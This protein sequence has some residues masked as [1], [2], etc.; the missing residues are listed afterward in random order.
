MLDSPAEIK[1]KL[2]KQ[3]RGLNN[4]S[5]TSKQR[6]NRRKAFEDLVE[7]V[8]QHLVP[9]THE[10]YRRQNIEEVLEI[11]RIIERSDAPLPVQQLDAI[12][13]IAT[14]RLHACGHLA[15]T[16]KRLKS[17]EFQ[18]CD[19]NSLLGCLQEVDLAIRT[20]GESISRGDAYGDPLRPIARTG[21]DS[22]GEIPGGL[23]DL[24][25]KGRLDRTDVLV[26]LFGKYFSYLESRSER[27]PFQ[28]IKKILFH[29]LQEEEKSAEVNTLFVE[30][31][32]EKKGL[33]RSKKGKTDIVRLSIFEN[34]TGRIAAYVDCDDAMEKAVHDGLMAAMHYMQGTIDAEV[35]FEMFDYAWSVSDTSRVYQQD[36]IGL[37][38]AIAAVAAYTGSE[39]D[40][41]IAVTG[42]LDTSGR[43]GRVDIREKCEIDDPSVLKI[44]VPEENRPDIPKGLSYS[45][46]TVQR[47]E[48][49]VQAVFGVERIRRI[50]LSRYKKYRASLKESVTEFL[51]QLSPSLY[52]PSLS[53][54]RHETEHQVEQFLS[55]KPSCL[56]ITGEA[57]MGK[58]WFLYH[59]CR[60]L[61]T[62]EHFLFISDPSR[63]V[64]FD[65]FI[66]EFVEATDNTAELRT[67]LNRLDQLAEC[68]GKNV[69]IILDALNE[70]ERPEDWLR[71]IKG[72][73]A[74]LAAFP[75]VKL[76]MSCKTHV[77]NIIQELANGSKPLPPEIWRVA[78]LEEFSDPELEELQDLLTRNKFPLPPICKY[79]Y[80]TS[81]LR[82]LYV[83]PGRPIP[84][85]ISVL[86]LMGEY[87]ASLTERLP[88]VRIL[89]TCLI[90]EL[91]RNATS[92]RV[93]QG[94]GYIVP[95]ERIA[96]LYDEKIKGSVLTNLGELLEF[97]KAQALLLEP[98][99][100]KVGLGMRF[101]F[102]WLAE[103]LMGE[104]LFEAECKRHP[105]A[106]DILRYLRSRKKSPYLEGAIKYICLLAD[107]PELLISLSGKIDDFD[108]TVISTFLFR[109][110]EHPETMIFILGRMAEVR[111]VRGRKIERRGRLGLYWQMLRILAAQARSRLAG[112][113]RKK[114]RKLRESEARYSVSLLALKISALIG[115]PCTE[116]FLS[117][118][119]DRSKSDKFRQKALDSLGNIYSR[120]TVA[121]Q[122]VILEKCFSFAR[123]QA[124]LGVIYRLIYFVI[125]CYMLSYT[126]PLVLQKILDFLSILLQAMGSRFVARA[127]CY[128]V[129]VFLDRISNRPAEVFSTFLQRGEIHPLFGL[130]ELLDESKPPSRE[131][132]IE[133][134]QFVL[135]A[136]RSTAPDRFVPFFFGT[137]ILYFLG[138]KDFSLV[139][140]SLGRLYENLPY[141]T[142]DMIPG[143]IALI[144]R[145]RPTDEAF[146]L[147]EV[148]SRLIIRDDEEYLIKG[149][150]EENTMYYPL[151][152]VG[153]ASAER[154]GAN[155]AK[156]EF[157]VAAMRDAT[158]KGKW[159]LVNHYLRELAAIGC[160]HPKSVLLTLQDVKGYINGE[161]KDTL[162]RTLASIYMT[163]LESVEMFLRQDLDGDN[164]YTPDIRSGVI[165]YEDDGTFQRI[166]DSFVLYDFFTLMF[167]QSAPLRQYVIELAGYA[168]SCRS[169][170][171]LITYGLAR[172]VKF[173]TGSASANLE[174]HG[175][176]VNH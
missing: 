117:A 12:R 172:L 120:S 57:G 62:R 133:L 45:I 168:K 1:K 78:T 103:F 19:E 16:V 34:G 73:V 131:R 158:A 39:I 125:R 98:C 150:N 64:N 156:I 35:R 29:I 153:R 66:Q 155:P 15:K 38:I 166:T 149:G 114:S 171:D 105:S 159:G 124:D 54:R 175:L 8:I 169:L 87:V 36:S 116:I 173:C 147:L 119:S 32:V 42:R 74:K 3:I 136:S 41:S 132:I 99:G 50:V 94:G 92:P 93:E 164:P 176:P 48:D 163:H 146:E 109:H 82:T 100:G 104:Y 90:S 69:V 10:T 95:Y 170:D 128:A 56:V 112:I 6:F 126:N 4:P 80:L 59:L 91:W 165:M 26:D 55:D 107:D 81:V 61:Q 160:I 134:E 161:T 68:T 111:F 143:I 22:S 110:L 152:P 5:C 151:T 24:Y 37:S 47:L 30:K 115:F 123:A 71:L 33:V 31:T 25:E 17:L 130:V 122:I 60:H 14:Y 108:H 67:I 18:I 53:V 113:V 76:V 77:W 23:R 118:I 70:A 7:R 9:F 89:L 140:G 21:L 65:Q 141:T 79:P 43:V 27:R 144:H 86:Q 157:F 28:E 139:K 148:V 162:I 13:N 75:S 137:R 11:I 142:R 51:A 96:A 174:K 154:Q 84:A 167:M 2:E 88:D 46:T 72:L 106:V 58:S 63:L 102:D 138:V 85:H 52:D 49:A 97:S 145:V 129:K 135:E 127:G 44:L 83:T 101:R 40:K 121:Q 20:Y